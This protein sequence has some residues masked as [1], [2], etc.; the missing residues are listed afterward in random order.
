MESRRSGVNWLTR[1]IDRLIASRMGLT[2]TSSLSCEDIIVVGY[3]KSGNTWFQNLVVGLVYGLNP[4]ITPDTVV[5]E[6]V[7]D[8]EARRFY[9]R[10][11]DI[12]FF[13]SHALP[14]PS[15]RRVIYLL[16]D[17][18]DVMVSYFH[19]LAALSEQTVDFEA[20]V[21]SGRGLSPCKWQDHVAAWLANPYGAGMLVVKYE[22][23]KNDC[24][25]ELARVCEFA[26]LSRPVPALQAVAEGSSFHAMRQKELDSGWENG[27]WP[28]DKF[29]IRRGEV[30]SHR[31]EM[32]EQLVRAF[33]ADAQHALSL[34]DY[35]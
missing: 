1:R 23:L 21:R 20:M 31:D 30:G 35:A 5:Q 29:F 15:Y 24:V 28:K 8:L 14:K 2:P 19:H 22:D 7:P 27:G 25:R 18:R 12:M 10:Y 33:T 34:A 6:L 26:G 3:P 32:P 17:G 13:K 4:A 9:R 16:R 11:R